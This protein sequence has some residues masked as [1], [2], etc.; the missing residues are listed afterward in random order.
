MTLFRIQPVYIQFF[1]S[2][3]VPR[4]CYGFG[5]Y[6]R[7]SLS[8]NAKERPNVLANCI[9]S[10]SSPAVPSSV[11]ALYVSLPVVTEGLVVPVSRGISGLAKAHYRCH[12]FGGL[13]VL[14]SLVDVF[15]CR[16]YVV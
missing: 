10:M 6:F 13:G 11:V 4:R 16:Q 2:Y 8:S 3:A 1:I 7:L 14:Y 5:I 12:L 9:R 15:S